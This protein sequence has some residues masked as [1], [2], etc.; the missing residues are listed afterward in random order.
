MAF[1]KVPS[2]YERERI[3]QAAIDDLVRQ[4][5][6]NFRPQKIVLFGSYAY[7]V[8]HPESDVDLLIVMDTDLKESRQACLI[9]ESLERDLFGLDILVRTPKNLQERIVLG[10]SFLEEI[11]THGLVIYEASNE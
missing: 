1:V 6:E 11:T 9:S 3:P 2:I 7:G 4:I 10:D 5:A 8:P